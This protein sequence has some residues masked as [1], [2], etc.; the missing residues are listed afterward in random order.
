MA[1]QTASEDR[2]EASANRA[3]AKPAGFQIGLTR[4]LVL[5]FGGLVLL[6]VVAVL[7]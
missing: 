7:A 1:G 2:T 4:G 3:D 5:S 6:A